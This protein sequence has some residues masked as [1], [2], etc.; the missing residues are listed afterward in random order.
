[1]HFGN[2]LCGIDSIKHTEPL[3]KPEHGL[4]F[5]MI[6]VDAFF[7][8]FLVIVAAHHQS[9]AAYITDT[10][11]FRAVLDEI[12]IEAATR[13]DTASHHALSD[14]GIRRIEMNNTVDVV[15]LKQK[16]R[17]GKTARETVQYKP[18]IPVMPPKA[19]FNHFG[20]QIVI[21][22]LSGGNDAVYLGRDFRVIGDV[23]A[24]LVADG[25]VNEVVGFA[26]DFGLGALAHALNAHD[27]VLV[28]KADKVNKHPHPRPLSIL[29][30]IERGETQ[31]ILTFPSP[32]F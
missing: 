17:L 18:V 25:N 9:A 6:I 11:D 21:H 23:P 30:G 12:V 19:F 15:I 32:S 24:E 29:K 20:D 14:K 28:H 3:K 27:D 31:K 7:D 26:K 10:V 16:F 2:G 22:H 4:G 5:D 1:M 8:R 13:T